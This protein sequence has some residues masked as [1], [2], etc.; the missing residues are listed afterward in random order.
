MI[1]LCDLQPFYQHLP[2]RYWILKRA[3]DTRP[4][5]FGGRP[6][7]VAGWPLLPHSSLSPPQTSSP[8]SSPQSFLFQALPLAMMIFSTSTLSP[9]QVEP[10]ESDRALSNDP[11]RGRGGVVGRRRNGTSAHSRWGS[12]PQERSSD[13]LPSE[14]AKT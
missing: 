4:V 7:P 5:L 13:L 14:I 3:P 11:G 12:S 10:P 8:D 9:A 2:S 6:P 1:M